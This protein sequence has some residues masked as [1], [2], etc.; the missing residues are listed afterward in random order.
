MAI[1]SEPVASTET[2][3]RRIPLG[4]IPTPKD[5]PSFR[6]FMPTDAD[7]SGLSVTRSGFSKPSG[8]GRNL[9]RPEKQY[10]V[11]EL[12]V[13]ALREIGLDVIPSPLPDNPGHAE[14]PQIRTSTNKQ[15]RPIQIQI[16][17]SLILRIYGPFGGSSE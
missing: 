17:E 11:A 3:L 10:Y 5:G 4:Y 14:I 12:S 7:E 2:A 15:T 1:G 9:A 13:A 16:A 8:V 6:A